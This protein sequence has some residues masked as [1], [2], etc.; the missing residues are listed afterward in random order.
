[1]FHSLGSTS[2]YLLRGILVGLLASLC[3]PACALAI[4]WSFCNG[5]GGEEADDEETNTSF[6]IIFIPG[7]QGASCDCLLFYKRKR[8]EPT[9]VEHGSFSPLVFSVFWGM[10]KEVTIFYKRLASLLS[11]KWTQHYS[12]IISWLRCII[13]FSLIRLPIRCLQGAQLAWGHPIGPIHLP[14]DLV[15]L[16]THFVI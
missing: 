10:A 16:E 15:R 13:S 14:I 12:T 1:M 6:I 11:E 8:K 5:G 2:L 4:C 9:E 3:E 7:T